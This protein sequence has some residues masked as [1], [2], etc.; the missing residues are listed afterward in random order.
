MGKKKKK[1][2]KTP[3]N[4]NEKKIILNAFYNKYPD[5][6]NKVFRVKVED[7]GN[8]L[9]VL[10]ATNAQFNYRALFERPLNELS[11]EFQVNK[12]FE[13]SEHQKYID[14]YKFLNKKVHQTNATILDMLE[15]Y[16]FMRTITVS[17]N[18][19]RIDNKSCY[20]SLKL[21][22][23]N[24][25][26]T[27]PLNDFHSNDVD[28]EVVYQ[29]FILSL[30]E[31]LLESI[32]YNI[33]NQIKQ[34]LSHKIKRPID[35]FKSEGVNIK[36][37]DCFL[38]NNKKN[39]LTFF[40]GSSKI[41]EMK[42]LISTY[43]NSDVSY[44]YAPESKLYI[45]K[46]ITSEYHFSAKTLDIVYQKNNKE[47]LK[48]Y[49]NGL[50]NILKVIPYYN[51]VMSS[52]EK[53]GIKIS[54][55]TSCEIPENIKNKTNLRKT[56][57]CYNDVYF[58]YKYGDKVI[59]CTLSIP[60]LKK[61]KD[62][63]KMKKEAER[64]IKLLAKDLDSQICELFSQQ[65]EKCK[66]ETLIYQSYCAQTIFDFLSKETYP[67][68]L[69]KISDYL[70]KGSD[71]AYISDNG[72]YSKS[73]SNYKKEYLEDV[74]QALVRIN[75]VRVSKRKGQ[76]GSF[77]VYKSAPIPIDVYRCYFNNNIRKKNDIFVDLK[78]EKYIPRKEAEWVLN[79][80]NNK[81]KEKDTIFILNILQNHDFVVS[82]K[83][84]II[85][86]F[87]GL[88]DNVKLYLSFLVESYAKNSIEQKILKSVSK[89]KLG[90]GPV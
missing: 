15:K 70:I 17:S 66:K 81:V 71:D 57:L 31:Q 48:D 42:K 9:V 16:W 37:I 49:K 29:H 13:I 77:N 8:V 53:Y 47:F 74:L 75:F 7:Y 59:P 58:G 35:V 44:E 28:L 22:D 67:H 2:K 72:K 6:Q 61:R 39:T 60:H 84:K 41:D 4:D 73:L 80:L 21:E 51:F 45:V 38:S 63:A 65:I 11:I 86:V 18:I 10:K 55:I 32:K 43:Q 25:N 68:S 79:Q 12:K 1:N 30:K 78:A 83:D 87:S 90:F 33:P 85:E 20:I 24:L 23:L 56:G 88:S 34:A 64:A 27:I 14:C 89:F 19:N 46:T 5:F 50:Q 26:L 62:Y 40:V 54:K 52:F 76:Y 3:L 82:N 36:E 69:S